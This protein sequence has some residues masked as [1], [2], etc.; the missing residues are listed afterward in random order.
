[1]TNSTNF[2]SVSSSVLIFSIVFKFIAMIIGVL[3]NVTVIIYTIFWC[4]EKT[5][6]SYLIGNLAL[7]DLLVCLTF[8]PLWIVEFI[9]TILNIESDQDLFCKL[10]RSTIWSLLFASVATIFLITVDR[11][12]FIVKP[13]KYPMIVTRRRVFLAISGIWLTA[14]GVYVIFHY[15]YIS[16]LSAKTWQ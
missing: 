12:L 11:Y 5:A 16:S 1:M 3:G 2:V 4:K 15:C 7:A 14:C 8:Y 13:L 10:S 9:Q 6:T